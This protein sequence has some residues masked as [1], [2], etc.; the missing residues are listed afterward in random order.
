VRAKVATVDSA[1]E[2]LPKD[3]RLV[4][5]NGDGGIERIPR[6]ARGPNFEEA[7]STR[8]VIVDPIPS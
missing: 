6:N 8:A 2:L 7:Q 4:S 1:A 3:L 5:G